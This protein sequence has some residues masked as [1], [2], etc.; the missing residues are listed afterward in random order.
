M[1]VD[2]RYALSP[3]F[4]NESVQGRSIPNQ[5]G[6]CLQSWFTES[7][8]VV[9]PRVVICR[10]RH[11]W[12]VA[13]QTGMDIAMNFFSPFCEQIVSTPGLCHESNT[14]QFESQCSNE[15]SIE[16]ELAVSFERQKQ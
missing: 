2:N 16:A 11:S 10:I 3:N 15:V 1:H 9:R 12:A 13:Q 6:P 7:S 14:A 8:R 4:L 5:S